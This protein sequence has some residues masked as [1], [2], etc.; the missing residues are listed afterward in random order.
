MVKAT[1]RHGD[2]CATRRERALTVSIVLAIAI[3]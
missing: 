2:S 1:S 3:G